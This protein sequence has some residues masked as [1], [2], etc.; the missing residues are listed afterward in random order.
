MPETRW[1]IAL[2]NRASRGTVKLTRELRE[3]AK[4]MRDVKEASA[5]LDGLGVG[6]G[7][8]RSGGGGGRRAPDEEAR[9]ATA[10]AKRARDEARTAERVRRSTERAQAANARAE[11]RQRREGERSRAS[12]ARR[13]ARDTRATGA[14]HE[15]A[16]RLAV[17]SRREQ[18]TL[19]RQR[20][21]AA[22]RSA[23]A[24][25]R[26]RGG[27]GGG[28]GFGAALGITGGI[29]GGIAAST[30]AALSTMLSL[31]SAAG[32]FAGRIGGAVLQMVAFREASLTTLRAMARDDQGNRLTGAAADSQARERFQF[33]RDF[34]RQTPLELSQVLDLQRQTSAAGFTGQ[35]NSDVVRAAADVGAF[36]PNDP[37]A[38]QHFLLG[39]GQLRN[40]SSV[41]LQDLRQTTQAAG[42][43]E[44]DVLREIARNAGVTQRAGEADTAFN[45]RIQQQQQ[46]GGFTGAQGVEGVLAALRARNGGDLGSFATAQSRTL[47]GTL[48][49][50]RGA[51]LD[52]VTSI[53]DIENLPGIVALKK[54]LNEVVDVL[55][56]TGPTATRLRAIFSGLVDEAAQFVADLG[57]K[58]GVAGMVERAVD[59][60]E[61]WAPLVRDVVGAFGGA[62]WDGLVAGLGDLGGA[63]GNIGSDPEGTV[64]FARELGRDLGQLLAFGIQT[65]A[66]LAA[67]ASVL[68]IV[69]ARLL[70]V[71]NGVGNL[72]GAFSDAGGQ[73]VQG[74]VEGFR[75]SASAALDEVS[76]WSGDIAGAARSALGIASPSRVF[77]DEIGAQI[78]A[79][80][81]LGIDSG[82]RDV[83]RSMAGIT[84][85]QGL[86]G[87]GSDV[88]AGRMLGF[89]GTTFTFN[90]TVQNGTA[91][92]GRQIADQAFEHF[93]DRM[94]RGSLA[95]GP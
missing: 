8:R 86:P 73:V 22:S 31:V 87:F 50:L 61:R 74:F 6:G 56:G 63:L 36:N 78:P 23:R 15:R 17:R 46:R 76:A 35:R 69:A 29:A 18:T 89:G 42:L 28:L 10:R 70:D 75:A 32:D 13:E 71:V 3:L 64:A 72:I 12:N 20:D 58:G 54:T 24:E 55:T 67:L 80:M 92:L 9:R 21:A 43:S 66:A 93:V 5:G 51:A 38:A 60:F 25:A 39:L 37:A 44:A 95:A 83:E 14:A 82:A 85:P 26:G 40:A 90:V 49:N 33:A 4:A 94:E 81:V 27:G 30:G 77:R 48:S 41:R 84:A 59:L 79:G 45:T 52:F 34:A 16:F 2:E 91:D 1:K 7:G 68:A 88:Q 57:G 65:T 53:E 47:M 11:A 19:F 62:A